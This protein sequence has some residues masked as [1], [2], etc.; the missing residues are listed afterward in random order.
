MANITINL[1]SDSDRALLD[2]FISALRGPQTGGNPMTRT[3]VLP[4]LDNPEVPSNPLAASPQVFVAPSTAAAAP[5]P[6][7]P[8]VP[9]ATSPAPMSAA[10]TPTGADAG[11][12]DSE[13]YPWDERIHSGAKSKTQAGIWTRRRNVP[14]EVY[15]QIRDQIKAGI[16]APAPPAPPVAAPPAPPQ[17]DP[18]APVPPG[19]N[20]FVTLMRRVA[21]DIGA[22][23]YGHEQLKGWIESLG[24]PT[25]TTLPALNG[26]PE[27]IAQ[28]NTLL[29]TVQ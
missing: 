11:E 23:R 3:L 1:D 22:H 9:A 26:K 13:G 27:L 28:L 17:P 4:P 20:P 14:D 10:P 24:D 29:D 15:F 25:A 7:V 12:L 2:A 18:G 21:A 5:L 6:T 8:A 19:L 16:P